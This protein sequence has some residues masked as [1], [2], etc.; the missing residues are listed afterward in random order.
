MSGTLTPGDGTRKSN[1]NFVIDSGVQCFSAR[2][3]IDGG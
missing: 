2:A 3:L 1:V